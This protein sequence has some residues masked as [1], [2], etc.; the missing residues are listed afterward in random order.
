[1]IRRMAF[2]AVALVLAGSL[3]A[4]QTVSRE[5]A[6]RAG[7]HRRLAEARLGRNSLELAI[8]EFRASIKLNPRDPETHFGL[9]EA[10]RRKNLMA[11]ARG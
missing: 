4:C 8:R 10:Y 1:M 11:E 7:T 2:A 6:M 9:A 3:T 5:D